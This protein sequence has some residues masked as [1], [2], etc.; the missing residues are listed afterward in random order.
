MFQRRPSRPATVRSGAG[1]RPL[2]VR[3]ARTLRSTLVAVLAG[4]ALVVLLHVRC[5]AHLQCIYQR[6]EV[7]RRAFLSTPML[8]TDGMSNISGCI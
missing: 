5:S 6:P 2:R 1:S 3:P 4:A 7:D 8:S